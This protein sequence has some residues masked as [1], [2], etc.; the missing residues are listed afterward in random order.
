[1]LYLELYKNN[2]NFLGKEEADAEKI[3]A[4][5]GGFV[6]RACHDTGRIM[7]LFLDTA[8]RLKNADARETIRQMSR[9]GA[10][11]LPIVLMTILFTGMVLPCRQ[12]RNLCVSALRLPL[13]A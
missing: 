6:I 3:C 8:A 13:A 7:Q 4:A 5:V 9:L 10:D 1:M 12:Q 2:L 11:S